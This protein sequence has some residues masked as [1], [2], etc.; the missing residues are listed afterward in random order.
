MKKT[1]S[2]TSG[3]Y[4]KVENVGEIKN[5]GIELVFDAT[6]VKVGNFE[7]NIKL[8]YAKN[9]SEVVKLQNEDDEIILSSWG[10]RVVA[11]PGLEYGTIIGNDY[12]RDESGNILIDDNGYPSGI[13]QDTVLGKVQPDFTFGISNS[14][15]YKG[16]DFTALFTF[17][18]GNYIWDTER[19][20]IS[21]VEYGQVTAYD[22]KLLDNSWKKP[23]DNS[24][25][26]QLRWQDSYQWG[27]DSQIE[28]PESP[29]KKG[30]WK[31]S[32]LVE[33]SIIMATADLVKA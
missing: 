17:S 11:K 29:T 5:S 14:L 7:W 27:W 20:N 10:A 21:F 32:E 18:G 31:F 16:F 19:A 30:N 2:Y 3:F 13:V 25:F 22:E 15:T 6:P 33:R 24:E 1:I 23:G 12:A 9:K 8:T 4:D 28:N 26:A